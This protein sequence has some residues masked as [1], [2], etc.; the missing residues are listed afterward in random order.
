MGRFAAATADSNQSPRQME[1][2]RKIRRQLALLAKTGENTPQLRVTVIERFTEKPPYQHL[3]HTATGSSFL[4]EADPT[5]ISTYN[6]DA[7]TAL[8]WFRIG[9]GPNAIEWKF[10]RD[11]SPDG[12]LPQDMKKEK[13]GSWP[14][15]DG[16]V[17][18]GA[19]WWRFG[20]S[21]LGDMS[22]GRA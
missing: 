9:D 2:G 22:R 21:P 13:V 3:L 17:L 1:S 14:R 18:Q 12:K 16:T 15:P 11:D 10:D 5:K 20:F 6:R 4:P 7:H 8:D 19:L